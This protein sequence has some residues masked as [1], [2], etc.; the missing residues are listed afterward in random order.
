MNWLKRFLHH[1]IWKQFLQFSGLLPVPSPVPSQELR[2]NCNLYCITCIPKEWKK[3]KLIME[4]KQNRNPA[5]NH[6]LKPTARITSTFLC[7]F[8]FFNTPKSQSEQC[9]LPSHL[10]NCTSDVIPYYSPLPCWPR[11]QFSGPILNL[12]IHY[13]IPPEEYSGRPVTAAKF[14]RAHPKRLKL[15]G[16]TT[17]LTALSNLLV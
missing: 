1:L 10:N 12:N 2:G 9:H 6:P 15:N 3:N 5:T 13:I 4:Q 7:F 8:T 14:L 11:T 17:S 16:V